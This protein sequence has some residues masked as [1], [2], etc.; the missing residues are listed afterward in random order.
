E[1]AMAAPED[2]LRAAIHR[3]LFLDHPDEFVERG[4]ELRSLHVVGVTAEA[5]VSPCGVQ[6]RILARFA[7]S[8]ET[9]QMNVLDPCLRKCRLKML[10]IE[11]RRVLRS[12]QRANVH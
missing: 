8:A 3:D 4:F 11:L 6:G 7:Q 2:G 1:L 12:R 10:E 9:F 5:I